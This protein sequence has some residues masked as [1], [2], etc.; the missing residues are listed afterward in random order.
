[1]FCRRETAGGA[2][3]SWPWDEGML[4]YAATGSGI[5]FKLVLPFFLIGNKDEEFDR[6]MF[7]VDMSC[8]N[9]DSMRSIRNF[10]VR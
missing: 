1:M 5:T 8:A 2:D 9:L 4:L 7:N 6:F 3:P 10:L